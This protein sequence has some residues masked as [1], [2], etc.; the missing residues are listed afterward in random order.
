MKT[1]FNP[2]AFLAGLLPGNYGTLSAPPLDYTSPR[3]G[4]L[5]L[6]YADLDAIPDGRELIIYRWQPVYREGTQ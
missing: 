3:F 1:T 6:T 4:A 5:T 2:Q